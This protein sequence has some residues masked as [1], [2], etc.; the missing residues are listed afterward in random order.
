MSAEKSRWFAFIERLGGFIP[1]SSATTVIAALVV[2]VVAAQFLAGALTSTAILLTVSVWQLLDFVHR[3]S[4]RVVRAKAVAVEVATL[5]VVV[6]FALARI[7]VVLELW[8]GV[9]AGDIAAQVLR[10][11]SV[12]VFIAFAASLWERSVAHLALLSRLKLQPVQTVVLS[13]GLAVVVGT[14]LLSLPFS[15]TGTHHISVLNALFV[16]TSAVCVTGLS[17]VDVA[18]TYTMF[19]HLVIMLLIQAGGLGIMFLFAAF[20]LLSGRQMSMR[21]EQE[22]GEASGAEGTGGFRRALRFILAMT[23]SVELL[24]ALSLF[25]AMQKAGLPIPLFHAVFHAVSAFCNAGFSTLPGGLM[26]SHA[27][28]GVLTVVGT[29]IVLGGL[30]A[31]VFGPLVMLARRRGRP[32]PLHPKLALWTTAV[33]LVVGTSGLLVLESGSSLLN[34]SVLDRIGQALFLSVSS[35]TA[36]FDAMGLDKLSAAGTA[37]VMMLMFIG[38]SPGS[39]GGGIKV[40]TFAVLGLALIAALRRRSAVTAFGKT[41]PTED[42]LR[43]TA[44][45]FSGLIIVSVSTLVLLAVESQPPLSL[46]F[47]VVSAFSTTG[48][49]VGATPSLSLAGRLVIVVMMFVGRIGPLTLMAAFIDRRSSAR[50]SYP[51]QHVQFG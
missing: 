13:F 42:V 45:A 25:P 5:S 35:R 14:L 4:W 27:G 51:T 47:E 40:T 12:V 24:G 2:D 50:V 3:K 44:I 15:V 19:G 22:L 48:L 32:M 30:G 18:T 39:T 29:L 31:P 10:G 38:A 20:A 8:Q 26:S 37:W 33:L 28:A 6:L 7:P 23:L 21:S 41:V 16:A 34:V 49:T 46:A 11:Y 17:V 43:A 9:L 1:L 36:G